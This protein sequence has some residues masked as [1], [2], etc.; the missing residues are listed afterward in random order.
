MKKIC[1]LL[2]A[3]IALP[4]LA[5]C[6][7]DV[8]EDTRADTEPQTE[9]TSAAEN[10]T[11][12]DTSVVTTTPDETTA[13]AVQEKSPLDGKK[14]VFIGNS[15]IYYGGTVTKGGYRVKDTGLFYNVCKANGANVTVI[16]CTYGNHSLS[17]FT[18]AGCH[19]SGCDVGVGGDLLKGLDLSS[20]DIVFMSEAG[21]NNANIV[22]DVKNI[23]SRFTNPDTLFVYM[24]H[25]YSYTKSHTNVT[26]N[27][28]ALQK[29]GI[30]IV[31]WGHVCFDVYQRTVKV[32]GSKLSYSKN[33]FVNSTS[34]DPHHPNPL[35]GYITSLMC[36]CAVTGESAVGKSYDMMSKVNFGAGSTSFADYKAKYYT[37]GTSNFDEVFKSETDM[38]GLQ[39]IMDQYLNKWNVGAGKGIPE[40]AEVC[41]H[42]FGEGKLVPGSSAYLPGSK[43]FVCSK[44]GFTKTEPVDRET[45]RINLAYGKTGLMYSASK[46]GIGTASRLTD[47]D[48]G[49]NAALQCDG[50]WCSSGS[51]DSYGG[52]KPADGYTKISVETADGKAEYLYG[53]KIDLGSAYSVDGAALYVHGY[54][55]TVMDKGFDILVSSDGKTWKKVASRTKDELFSGNAD[56]KGYENYVNST[57]A[58]SN[59]EDLPAYVVL[60]FAAESDVRY[61]LYGCTDCRDINGYYTG[62]I[63]EFEVYKAK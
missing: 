18:T 17:D 59:A 34:S 9:V 63:T 49:N 24:C 30:V 13:Q 61:V 54:K 5:S 56:G 11:K 57:S 4:L 41:E 12:E 53:V 39:K 23:M 29:L 62:R 33:T 55:T 3:I 2:A 45:G 20:F 19:T 21:N 28:S 36:Y 16:D 26:G 32:E 60:D 35:A 6:A 43:T 42:V 22:R 7:G 15:M 52:K 58:A 44:C 46:A 37:S 25:T 31:D 10:G 51:A 38:L 50:A 14:V 48:I 27:L 8:P 47:G 40:P 1:L